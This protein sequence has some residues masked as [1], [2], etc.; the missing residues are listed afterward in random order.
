MGR[1]EAWLGREAKSEG[2]AQNALEVVGTFLLANPGGSASPW[3]PP[4]GSL[5][6][7]E[8][9]SGDGGPAAADDANDQPWVGWR[10]SG[11]KVGF[12]VEG[13]GGGQKEVG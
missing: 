13:G 11:D 5:P 9:G 4:D 3:V 1:E 7:S 6:S 2:E 10:G 8:G 12:E